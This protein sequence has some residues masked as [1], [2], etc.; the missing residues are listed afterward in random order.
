MKFTISIETD[1][2]ERDAQKVAAMFKVLGDF[3][4]EGHVISKGPVSVHTSKEH[5]ERANTILKE[6][7]P[8]IEIEAVSPEPV[9]DPAAEAPG[10]EAPPMPDWK[11]KPE[12]K[13]E[14]KKEAKPEPKTPVEAV[15]KAI[16]DNKRDDLNQKARRLMLE[17]TKAGTSVPDLKKI[18][19]E[20]VGPD[21]TKYDDAE[22]TKSIQVMEGLLNA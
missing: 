20:K 12:P 17:V 18:L 10:F 21:P 15:T 4:P 14:P 19:A 22:L 13:K 9:I 3:P 6:Q 1:G 8:D 16:I 11:P 5:K 7:N 2:T